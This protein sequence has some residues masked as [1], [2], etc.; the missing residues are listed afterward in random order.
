MEACSGR[1]WLLL[2]CGGTKALTVGVYHPQTQSFEHRSLLLFEAPFEM[3]ACLARSWLLLI[4]A[5]TKALTVGV[6]PPRTQNFE[7]RSLLCL[8]AHHLWAIIFFK[9]RSEAHLWE[10]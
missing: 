9:S 1:N 5:G 7:H 6:Y 2:I 3:E 8:K 10:V 4:C